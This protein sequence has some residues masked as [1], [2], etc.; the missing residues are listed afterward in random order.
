MRYRL[1]Q[2]LRKRV[3]HGPT[4]PQRDAAKLHVVEN[5]VELERGRSGP[6]MQPRSKLVL[7]VSC[8]SNPIVNLLRDGAAVRR[9][10]P[11]FAGNQQLMRCTEC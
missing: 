7:R 6:V 4:L 5:E 11:R 3:Q 8:A 9:D 2:E 1:D 10:Q